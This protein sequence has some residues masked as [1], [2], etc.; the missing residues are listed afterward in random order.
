[1]SMLVWVMMAI[2][3]WHFTVFLPDRFW[4]GI[5]GAFIGAV[6]G[7]AVD[8]RPLTALAFGVTAGFAGPAFVK[9]IADTTLRMFGYAVKAMAEEMERRPAA[10]E[11]TA[12]ARAD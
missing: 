4:S 1:M 3:I 11:G 2:A 10:G 6:I 7:A 12:A 8:G 5:V 9:V